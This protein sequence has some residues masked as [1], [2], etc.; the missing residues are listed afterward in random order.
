LLYIA[1]L[2]SINGQEPEM[3]NRDWD[4]IK[5]FAPALPAARN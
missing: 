3:V 1:A 5:N 4:K 2:L